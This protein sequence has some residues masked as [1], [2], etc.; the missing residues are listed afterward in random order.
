MRKEIILTLVA[1]L[2]CSSVN[3][4]TKQQ[5]NYG[6]LEKCVEDYK[7]SR[8]DPSAM[9]N[10]PRECTDLIEVLITARLQDEYKKLKDSFTFNIAMFYAKATTTFG[11]INL[12][13]SCRNFKGEYLTGIEKYRGELTQ[14]LRRE[15][16]IIEGLRKN[17][18]YKK[19][20]TNL[21][22]RLDSLQNEAQTHECPN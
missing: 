21:F 12:S 22:G 11:S 2:G 18:E 13:D 4:N 7:K 14:Q 6:W 1:L 16:V 3:L 17:R 20:K 5:S 9:K 15:E 19:A 8:E 10:S